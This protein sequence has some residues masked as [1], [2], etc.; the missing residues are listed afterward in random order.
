MVVTASGKIQTGRRLK[1]G[2]EPIELVLGL[3]GEG[4]YKIVELQQHKGHIKTD[5]RL[6][7]VRSPHTA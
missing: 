7:R 5:E 2:L 1:D 3:A 4:A 6:T